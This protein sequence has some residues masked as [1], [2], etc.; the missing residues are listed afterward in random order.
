MI[1][2]R[3]RRFASQYFGWLVRFFY[4]CFIDFQLKISDKPII[5]ILTPGKV[6]SS[7]LYFNLKKNLKNPIYHVHRISKLGIGQ[8]KEEHLK[9]DR[10]SLPLHLIISEILHEKII[11]N[12]T[13]L[14]VITVIRE[15][16]SRFVSSYFQNIEFYK[17]R[18]ESSNLKINIDASLEILKENCT[19]NICYEL[20]NWFATEIKQFFDIDVFGLELNSPCVILKELPFIFLRL[21]DL[22]QA[23]PLVANELSLS[24]DN[25]N[26]KDFNVGDNKYYSSAYSQ[27]REQFKLEE[28]IFEEIIE[29]KFYKKFYSDRI[30]L[31]RKKWVK[32]S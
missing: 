2:I 25:A 30:K 29:T 11:R 21:E 10:K 12:R 15:P 32:T 18:V 22:Q 14:I 6:G 23:W 17:N 4:I 5:L 28:D 31:V 20:E 13:N 7:S 1:R 27:I 3:L 8:S 16:I 19:A 26:L 9:S 24:K